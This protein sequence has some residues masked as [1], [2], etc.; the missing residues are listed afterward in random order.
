MRF[1]HEEPVFLVSTFLVLVISF[2]S[3]YVRYLTV[4][5]PNVSPETQ[6]I[7]VEFLSTPLGVHL[8]IGSLLGN[9]ILYVFILSL[10][11]HS[12]FGFILSVFGSSKADTY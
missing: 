2:E 9:I 7:A 4:Q 11:F 10:L 6:R 12:I 3:Y 1:F 5:S 8:L